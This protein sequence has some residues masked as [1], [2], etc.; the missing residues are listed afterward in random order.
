MQIKIIKKALD[1][2]SAK[3]YYIE[4]SKFFENM[5]EGRDMPRKGD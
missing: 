2:V 4:N 5:Y 1:A 3:W